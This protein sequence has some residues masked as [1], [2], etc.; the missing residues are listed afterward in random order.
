MTFYDHLR[1]A[2]VHL[3]ERKRQTMLTALGVAVGS[4][5]MITTIAVARG[6]TKNVFSKLIDI[7]PHIVIGA[8]RVVPLVPDNLIGAVTGRVAM[9]EKN[10]TTD[11]KET[12]K[13]YEQVLREIEPVGEIIDVSPF[14]SSKLLVRNKRRFEP[15]IARGVHPL[16]EAN[17]ANLKKNLLEP[18][19]LS[20]L[21]WTPNGIILGDL[22]AE[23][24]K[25]GYRDRV[26]LVTKSGEEYPVTVVGRFKSGFNV[27]DQREAFVNLALAQ[28]M[29]SL[30]SNAV[31]GIGIRVT[32]IA[33]AGKVAA[34]IE[35]ITGYNTE[36]WDETNRNVIE[37]YSRNSTITLVLVGFVFV[38]AGLGVASVM[39]TVVLQ[40]VKDIA[41]MRSM[42]V[43]RK[44]ITRIFMLEGLM[45]G[46]MGVL[47]GSPVGHLACKLIA[48][49]RFRP[50][51]AGVISSDRLLIVETPD[52]YV[53]VIV[54]GILIAVIS[55]VGPARRATN[56]PPVRVLRG[57]VG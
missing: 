57:E 6:S 2:F 14:V 54:F 8:D 36:S 35:G 52:A 12:I 21:T 48:D 18:D 25:V 10:V 4:A 34:R 20:E 51:S 17:M 44:S 13:N 53:M 41:I 19:A 1:I 56:Y 28:R 33:L 9:V 24:L 49:V 40:K 23:K 50:S 3:R 15:C 31:T 5:M 43:Q 45:M 42:G 32:D 55:S 47:L 38:V 7:V 26:M 11:R 46:T 37:F 16:Q 39:T 27:K 22:L 30:A 29:E